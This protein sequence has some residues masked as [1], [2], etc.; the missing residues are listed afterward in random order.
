MRWIFLTLVLFILGFNSLCQTDSSHAYTIGIAHNKGFIVSHS[1]SMASLANRHISAFELYV[2]QN[3]YGKKNWHARYPFLKIGILTKYFNLNNENVLGNAFSISPYLKF[4][5]YT[6]DRLKFR[7]KPAVGIAYLGNKFNADDNFENI[8]IGSHLNLSLSLSIE[9]EIQLFKRTFTTLGFGL[10]HFSN[11]GFKTPN[12]GLNMPFITAGVAHNFGKENAL[13]KNTVAPFQRK[14]FYW[15]VQSG[16]GVNEINPP[17]QKKYVASSVSITREK[18]MSRKSSFGYGLDFYYN[19]AQMAFLKKDSIQI[20]SFENVQI[21]VSFLYILHFGELSFTSQLSYYLKTENEELGN[22]YHV[23][24][25]RYALN[26]KVNL[27]ILGKT[28]IDKAEF[29]LVGIGY[30]FAN[31]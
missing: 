7:F 3:T 24:G 28:H 19:P 18:K 16:A 27:F 4:N 8:A 2:E 6:S 5:L 11:A 20:N 22:I 13:N 25:A 29:I 31:E 10:D 1:P 17:N 30:K 23:F 21:G 12:L 14:P 15:Y 26:N 9:T